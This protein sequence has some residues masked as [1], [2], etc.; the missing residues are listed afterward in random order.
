M[1][2]K[3]RLINQLNREPPG[4]TNRCNDKSEWVETTTIQPRQRPKPCRGKPHTTSN[5][6]ISSS[7]LLPVDSV[8]QQ[9]YNL[10][11]IGVGST[12]MTRSL[13]SGRL[14]NGQVDNSNPFGDDFSKMTPFQLKGVASADTSTVPVANIST[15]QRLYPSLQENLVEG[16]PTSHQVWFII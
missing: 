9:T 14:P 4:A 2:T 6:D 5:P 12:S 15:T 7:T 11:N 1:E 3:R 10:L 13:D 16:P 8:H